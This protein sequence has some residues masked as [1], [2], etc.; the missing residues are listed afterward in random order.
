MT[1]ATQ[2]YKGI[3][4][5]EAI[6]N[7]CKA[8][9]TSLEDLNVEILTPGSN[10]FLGIGKRKAKIRASI[11]NKKRG[12][13]RR[14][15]P[16]ETDATISPGL[17]DT[18]KETLENIL[19]L[20]DMGSEVMVEI[21]GNR[22][23]AKINGDHVEA[24]TERDG[25]VLDSLQYLMRKIVSR[26][27]TGKAIFNLDAGDYRDQRR[28]NLEKLAVQLAAETR[29]SGRTR[30]IASLNPAERRIVH[31]ALKDETEIKSRS[32]GDGHFKKVLIYI[33][34]QGNKGRRRKRK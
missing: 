5:S 27:V 28:R 4:V 13:F 12:A 26:N 17:A 16:R 25:S 21:N 33:P 30:A 9:N 11:K 7:A 24:I 29:E 23:D 10:G 20:M 2:E 34:G 15:R 8:L 32:V 19:S 6:A 22:I 18:L 1:P 14:P 31:M 3:D